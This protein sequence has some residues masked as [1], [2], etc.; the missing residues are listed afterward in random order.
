MNTIRDSYQS[1]Y[2]TRQSFNEAHSQLRA[3]EDAAFMA[4]LDDD[5]DD[6][7]DS[8]EMQRMEFLA[9]DK[10]FQGKYIKA[11]IDERKA[12][13]EPVETSEFYRIMRE[14]RDNGETDRLYSVDDDDESNLREIHKESYIVGR[15]DEFPGELLEYMKDKEE[16]EYS[17]MSARDIRLLELLHVKTN[18]DV[19]LEPSPSEGDYENYSDL[20]GK[21]IG[22]QKG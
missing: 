4:S 22:E 11:E 13:Y 20:A 8:Q 6:V 10:D 1:Q 2:P 12:S 17:A 16:K 5:S 9:R 19:D 15:A 21:T 18:H 14:A 7:E 3:S